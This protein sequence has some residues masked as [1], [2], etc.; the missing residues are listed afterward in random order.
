MPT[1]VN[2]SF[3][4][5]DIVIPNL[6]YSADQDRINSFISKYEPE[7]LLKI[8][9]YPLFK[10]F[11]TE[12]SQRMTDLLS[13]AEYTDGEGNLRK[14]QGLVH[15]TD[16]SLIANYVYFFYQKKQASQSM[17]V[18]TVLPKPE[19]GTAFSPANLMVD[20]W[21]FFSSEVFDMTHFLW[22]KKDIDGN[23]VYTE[24]TY[25]QYLQTRNSTRFINSVFQF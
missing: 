18:G 16:I 2:T 25:H 23:R 15:D 13:G 3:F 21:N 8:L 19:A 4:V 22:L 24:F 5:R 1:I 17:G 7:C 12:S 14:W 20:A 10:V 9:G 11:G 6:T